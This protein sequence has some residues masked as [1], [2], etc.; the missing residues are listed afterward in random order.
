MNKNRQ[1]GRTFW[2]SVLVALLLVSVVFPAAADKSGVS[3]NVLSLPS[4]P[5]SIEGLGDAFEVQLNSGTSSYQ[6]PLATPP[7]RAGFGPKLALSY[8]SGRRMSAF[9]LGWNLDIPFIQRRVEQGQPFYTEWPAKNRKDDDLD[10][11]EDEYDEFDTF[12]FSDGTEIIP[13]LDS[14][15]GK[16]VWRCTP[17]ERFL[18][19]LRLDNGGWQVTQPDGTVLTF[20]LNPGARVTAMQTADALEERTFLWYVDSMTDTHGNQIT[21]HYAY[22]DYS[23][24]TYLSKIIYNVSGANSMS[25]SFTYEER[26]D[27]LLDYRPGFELKTGFRVSEILMQE[28]NRPVRAYRLGYA[29]TSDTQ[30]LSLLTSVT[31]VAPD[32][33][34]LP[35]ATF[36]YTAFEQ[37]SPS[38]R[39]L[40][41]LPVNLDLS[42]TNYEVLDLN[43]DALPD[44]LH[45]SGEKHAYLLNRGWDVGNN[46]LRWDDNWTR[47]A[48][49]V[50]YSLSTHETWLADM[51][52]NART[53]LV[54]LPDSKTVKVYGLNDD[55]SWQHFESIT[56]TDELSFADNSV[57]WLDANHDRKIDVQKL[58]PDVSGTTVHTW[59]S[60]QKQD[61]TRMWSRKYETRL[62]GVNLSFAD[63]TTRLGDMNGDRIADIVVLEENICVYYPG[64]GY[65]RYGEAVTLA[66]ASSLPKGAADRLF[67]M[68][69][70]GDGLSD[71]VSLN[72]GVTVW[73]NLGLAPGEP[74]SIRLAA[75]FTVD[76]PGDPRD[77]KA[78]R[79][80]DMNGNGSVDLIWQTYANQ[81]RRLYFLD[82]AMA[83]Q[84]YQM[85]TIGNGIGRV[86]T[87]GY[88]SSVEEMVRDAVNGR[89]WPERVP[90]AVPVVSQIDVYDGLGATYT[91]LLRY[92]DGSYDSLEEEFR[93]FASAEQLEAGDES[94][95]GLITAYRFDVGRE[96]E[97]LKGKPLSVE[98]GIDPNPNDGNTG[99]LAWPHWADPSLAPDPAVL[100]SRTENTWK[101]MEVA[102]PVSDEELRGVEFPYI[103][104]A[105]QT[106]YELGNGEPVTIQTDYAYDGYGNLIRKTEHGRLDAGWDDERTIETT[107]TAA[108]EAGRKAWILRLPVET[109]MFGSGGAIAG[110]SRNYYDGSGTLGAVTLGDATRMDNW[111]SGDRW[112]AVRK[113]FDTYGNVTAIYDALYTDRQSGHYRTIVYDNAYQTFP[114][115]ESIYTGTDR[116]T[117]EELVLTM[118][119]EYDY[120]LGVVVE[121]FDFHGERS[122]YGYDAFGRR[123]SM[124]RPGETEAGIFYTYGLAETLPNGRTINW[125]ETGAKDGSPGD[126]YLRSRSFFDG[127]GRKVMSRSEDEKAGQVV[128]SDTVDFNGRKLPWREY[129]PYFE[130]GTLEYSEPPADQGKFLERRYDA[131]GRIVRSIKPRGPEGNLYS[132]TIYEPL[133][134]I[135]RNEEQTREGSA[136]NG[137]GKRFVT[138]GLMDKDG[139]G[140]LREVYEIVK[141][142]D[143]GDPGPLNH[144]KTTYR[145]DALNGLTEILDAQNNRKTMQ[146]D[147]LG[148]ILSMNDPNRGT[149]DYEYDAFGNLVGTVDGKGQHLRFSYDGANR[150][151]AEFHGDATIPA[152]KYH[153]D[154]PAGELNRGRFWQSGKVRAISDAIIRGDDYRQ[155]YDLNG[156]G[157]V[158][159]ADA[160]KVAETGSSG[161]SVRAEYTLGRLAWVEHEAG[162]EHMSYDER[163]RTR[164]TIRRIEEYSSEAGAEPQFQNFYSGMTYDDM[165][166]VVQFTYPDRTSIT[167]Q[168]NSRGLLEAIPGVITEHEYTAAGNLGLLR[169]ANGVVTRSEFD[170]RLRPKSIRAIRESDNAVLQDLQYSLNGVSHL[171]SIQD[172]RLSSDFEKIGRDLGLPTD[173]AQRF[174]ATQEFEFDSLNRLTKVS[175]EKGFGT[176]QYRYDRIGN[177]IGKD[178]QL[179]VPDPLMDLGA[180]TYGGSEGGAWN[181]HG[182]DG[183]PG[184]HAVTNTEKGP[185]GP[186]QLTYDGNGNVTSDRGMTLEWDINDRLVRLVKGEKTI[187]HTYDHEGN[188]KRTTVTEKTG[189]E[190]RVSGTV[191][192][193]DS[194]TEVRNGELVKY[195]YTGSNRVARL[196]A[197]S[198]AVESF[199]L[200]D[201]IGS[202]TMSLSNTATVQEIFA[203]YPYGLPRL[204]HRSNGQGR[205]THYTFT[206]KEFDEESRF[207][208]FGARYYAP[209]LARFLSTD[210]VSSFITEGNW[211]MLGEPQVLNLYSYVTNSPLILVDPDGLAKKLSVFFR[212][213]TQFRDFKICELMGEAGYNFS[214][215]ETFW[216]VGMTLGGMSLQGGSENPN[217]LKTGVNSPNVKLFE[218]RFGPTT[219]LSVQ[220]KGA[221]ALDFITGDKLKL[222]AG[223]PLTLT[224]KITHN[225]IGIRGKMTC[226]TGDYL[227]YKSGLI[228]PLELVYRSKF[229]VDGGL[230][231]SKELPNDPKTKAYL[232]LTVKGTF[233]G[234]DVENF[235]NSMSEIIDS[236]KE[237]FFS[238]EPSSP[239][240]GHDAPKRS[241]GG[242]LDF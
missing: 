242:P 198:G 23:V 51:D 228:S 209:H 137:A 97:A 129:L 200:Y 66:N 230:M 237:D 77:I 82:F 215:Q 21:F 80:A 70:N 240:M 3:P 41:G 63:K 160:L 69:T 175:Q 11:E 181:R 98:V 7:G 31:Q 30:P 111:V 170:H 72:D 159:V 131:R 50:N 168:Y 104:S 95:P 173:E 177:M 192:Y 208:Y 8:N 88:G 118:S 44:L 17:E 133:A 166:R 64:M 185:D 132:E 155:D 207:S 40:T 68:D 127:L 146:Y 235:I 47:M 43:A 37:A 213:G 57:R 135:V 108:F 92:H 102:S 158:D 53:D 224:V 79:R 225:S 32:G 16:T 144:W 42:D 193:V 106:I 60:L 117:G 165:D 9:G 29:E 150:L 10:G 48:S 115:Q 220:L 107:Y 27:V 153:Y 161:A 238:S 20:G 234:T 148:R 114:V 174:T 123:T 223:V 85:K 197:E 176:I 1:I 190:V 187:E 204:T 184:P 81:Q 125:I 211:G 163:G 202:T 12:M 203:N 6:V 167:Y 58:I 138:D 139:V 136:H 172:G 183:K 122:L 76:V 15:S 74:R 83:A 141:L 162:E 191:F 189:S 103:A 36:T 179:T 236:V 120:G 196:G 84:P 87:L 61:G 78:F 140:R 186:M 182:A 134:K 210:D 147:G 22:K 24:Q 86:T 152:V 219:K 112:A 62:T 2:G 35:P 180:M 195:V 110:H 46:T 178:A 90:I 171:H 221:G 199:Y 25:V 89:P 54:Y 130:T 128:V 105:K 217:T 126:G 216:K 71:V 206:N 164:W 233:D 232:D 67:L 188:R 142:T 109:K 100:F 49:N 239:A 38:V 151:L 218:L 59:I 39:E 229:S 119:A 227:K 26:P 65:G 201:Q 212:V 154:R 121:S 169:Y 241:K 113:E 214:A 18:R 116:T 45:T 56:G 55:L 34:T 205:T 226:S 5:G 13:T 91:R 101:L 231:L 99:T 157:V 222:K 96:H 14:H 143:S 52:G 124:T 19:I 156:D 28:S 145:Y 194:S 149:M 33:K 93:G 4:G 73:L 75:P 94:I